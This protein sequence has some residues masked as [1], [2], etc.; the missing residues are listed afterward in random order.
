[1]T[2]RL[3]LL[4]QVSRRTRRLLGPVNGLLVDG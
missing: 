4:P 3:C 1:L 2:H